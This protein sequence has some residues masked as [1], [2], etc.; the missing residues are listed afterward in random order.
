MQS[1][2]NNPKYGPKSELGKLCKPYIFLLLIPVYFR[3]QHVHIP[4]VWSSKGNA[5]GNGGGILVSDKFV[6]AQIVGS[7]KAQDSF[8]LVFANTMIAIQ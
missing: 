5:N 4:Q 2:L 7:K 1:I 6:L 3:Y 8:T